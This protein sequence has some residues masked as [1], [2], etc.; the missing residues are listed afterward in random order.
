MSCRP[1][2][3]IGYVEVYWA[4]DGEAFPAIGDAPAGNWTK[5][6]SQGAASYS[7][8]GVSIQEDKTF[9]EIKSLKNIDPECMVLTERNLRVTLELKDMSSAQIRLA[10]NNN[11][12]SDTATGNELDLDVIVDPTVIAI[13]VRGEDKS[14]DEEGENLQFEFE[15][16]VEV[17]SRD[18]NFN[19]EDAAMAALEFRVL[20]GD[21]KFIAGTTS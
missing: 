7:E 9:S 10:F 8:A 6:G 4:P 13:L 15:H 12:V 18:I 17:G 14:P 19:K 21:K 3:V 5:I 2:L 16:C 11:A 20:A 1:D